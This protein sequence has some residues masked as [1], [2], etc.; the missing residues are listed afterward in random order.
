[1]EGFDDARWRS[2]RDSARIS[3]S[4]V[5][6]TLDHERGDPKAQQFIFFT[7]QKMPSTNLLS[8]VYLLL[9]FNAMDLTENV[10]KFNLN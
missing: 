5:K 4:N 7:K 6:R 3:S 8:C 2:H 1:M 9:L 10:T